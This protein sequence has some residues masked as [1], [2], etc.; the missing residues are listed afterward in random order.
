MLGCRGRGAAARG[1]RQGEDD[2]H[3]CGQA[4]QLR[5]PAA[6]RFREHGRGLVQWQVG[7]E[8]AAARGAEPGCGK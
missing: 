3:Q 1:G 5:D 7:G 2:A 4:Q 8:R 6:E